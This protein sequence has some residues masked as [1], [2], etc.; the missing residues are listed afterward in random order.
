MFA[1]KDN[2]S[3]EEIVLKVAV[4]VELKNNEMD[5]PLFR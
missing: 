2:L 4:F 5:K 1:A 3:V